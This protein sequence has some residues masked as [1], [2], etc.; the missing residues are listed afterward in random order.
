MGNLKIYYITLTA[1]GTLQMPITYSWVT[2]STEVT[3]ASPQ[4]AYC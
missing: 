3:S 1:V 4:S 2:M